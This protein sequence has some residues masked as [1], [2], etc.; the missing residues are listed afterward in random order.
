MIRDLELAFLKIHILYHATKEEVF[1]IGLTEELARHGYKVGPGTLYP[2][3]SK[4]EK[5]GFL[6]C[7]ARTV[8]H[9]QRKY[10]R[11]T[12]EGGSLL[13]MMKNKI[14]ELYKEVIEGK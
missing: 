14:I 4:L 6:T 5:A 10:Y 8:D 9:K 11:I 2:T 12:R 7:E 13:D 3:L 1:G